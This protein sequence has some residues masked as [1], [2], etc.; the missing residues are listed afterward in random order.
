MAPTLLKCGQHSSIPA[1]MWTAQLHS[2]ASIHSITL[3]AQRHAFLLCSNGSP[4]EGE[5]IELSGKHL[6]KLSL[7]NSLV[8]F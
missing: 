4:D 3:R 8:I 6:K 7:Q 5:L 2:W 1:E